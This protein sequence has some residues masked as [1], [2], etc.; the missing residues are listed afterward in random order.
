MGWQPIRAK[1]MVD[2]GQMAWFTPGDDP[3]L[4]WKP[5]A[6][7]ET[8]RPG[9]PI[10]GTQQFAHG[11]G[12]GDL[13][14]DGRLDVI[15]TG[16]WWE[17]PQAGRKA[18]SPWAFHPAKLGDAVA[19][20]IAYDVNGDGLADVVASSAHKFGIWWFEQGSPKDGSPTFTRHDLF[21]DWSPRRTP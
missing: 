14:G 13:N 2:E 15:C 4:P 21:P 20:M 16:G 12:V 17:Q 5:H 8:G 7:S 11:L 6:I 18:E 10:P 9:K 19:D 1:D 3:N